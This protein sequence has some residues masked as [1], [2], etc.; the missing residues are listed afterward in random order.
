M[1]NAGQVRREMDLGD[2]RGSSRDT[3][4]RRAYVQLADGTLLPVRGVETR[5]HPQL[6]V[7]VVFDTRD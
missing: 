2:S 6:G 5:T 1:M 4:D 7:L 3:D